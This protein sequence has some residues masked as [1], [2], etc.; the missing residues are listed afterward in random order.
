MLQFS[1]TY[2]PYSTQSNTYITDKDQQ[3]SF[4]KTNKVYCKDL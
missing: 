4:S 2:E 3:T 1:T